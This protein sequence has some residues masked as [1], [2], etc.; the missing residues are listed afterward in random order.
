[1]AEDKTKLEDI[2]NIEKA[3]KNYTRL[4][5]FLA[6]LVAGLLYLYFILSKPMEPLNK[7]NLKG[8]SHLFSIYGVGADRLV[9]PTEVAVDKEGN[10]YVADTMK[11]R[12]I[13]FNEDGDYV[14][15]FGKKGKGK[16][17][18]E[19]PSAV[20]VDE[21]GR[22]YV[23]SYTLRKL[24]I[25]NKQHRPVW[26]IMI[27][28]GPLT[29][30][31]K[32]GKLY[33]A[34]R[35]GVM[36]GDL[37]GNLLTYFDRPGRRRGQFNRPTGIAVDDNGNMYFA[38]SMNYRVQAMDKKGKPLW[39]VGKPFK[40]E[41]GKPL[42]ELERGRD[43]G[44]PQSLTLA[45]DGNLYMMDA[46]AGEI[47]IYDKKGKELGKVGEW[48]Q[49]DGQFYFPAGIASAGGEKF[50]IADK[51]NNRVQVVRIPSPTGSP[52]SVSGLP[53][54]I[55]LIILLIL[56]AIGVLS[57]MWYRRMKNQSAEMEA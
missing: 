9:K 51:F 54:N 46:F 7:P 31:V 24:V 14:T 49:E 41:R 53:I 11:S 55:L 56:S 2:I 36:I 22:V 12:I 30:I 6:I 37:K 15:M 3:P 29:S 38:D 18:L 50:A 19:F 45:P 20:S 34:T 35:T 4:I 39:V 23:I 10:I 47:Y 17:D 25:F 13:V 44:L 26:A 8:Y 21:N 27:K 43:F 48:G 33:V 5:I 42:E 52:L 32:K 1:M 28:E 16:Y 57:W 40:Y